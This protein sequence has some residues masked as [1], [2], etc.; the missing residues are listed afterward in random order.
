MPSSLRDTTNRV[1]EALFKKGLLTEPQLKEA[2]EKQRLSG[3][4]LG[5]VLIDLGYVTENQVTEALSE[6]LGIP[7]IDVSTYQIDPKIFALFPEEMLREH[8]ILPLFKVDKTITVA[9]VDPLNIRVTDRLRFLTHCE[10][11]PL[12]GA[13]SAVLRALDKNLGSAG[14]LEKVMRDIKLQDGAKA[15]ALVRPM[16]G[17][18]SLTSV[19]GS[20]KP[21]AA[22]QVT[23]LIAAAENAPVVKI[24]DTIIK[25]AVENRA[26]DIHIEP[27]ESS[28]YLRYR[29]DGV[30]YDVPPP[31]KN[32]EAAV[33]SRIKIMG[34]MDIAERRLP[35]DG[36][37]QVHYGEKEID[38]RVSS[39]PTIYG[40]NLSLRVLDKSAITLN[41]EDL[42]FDKEVLRKYKELLNRPHGILLVTG[43][44]GCGKT[45]TLYASLRTI[46]AVEKN[47]ITLEDPVEYRIQRV[48][49]AQVDVKA[50][51]TF[52]NGLRSILRQDPDII[53][54]G[55]IRDLETAEIAIH[56]ALTGHMVFSTL[57][58]N[59]APGAL[60]RLAD[61]GVEPFLAVSSVVGVLA[62]RLVRSLC[63]ECK[64]P[65]KPTPEILKSLGVDPKK[66]VT[67]Y[68]TKGCEACKQ[69]GYRGRAALFEL[70]ETSDKIRDLLL[71]KASSAELKEQAIRDGMINLRRDGVEK[72]IKGVTTVEEVLRVTEQDFQE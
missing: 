32:L 14:S 21:A 43:P 6:Q 53:L 50:G 20:G 65:Y 16:G 45:T 17:G 36:R 26:S 10:I 51:L 31:P 23:S 57:H 7:F 40:E 52:A 5:E 70:M 1:G 61:M 54:I 49:Q 11:E 48:R 42:G 22:D 56:S 8:L 34:N 69:T 72:V 9:M 59:D 38:L 13:K 37:I 66:E 71:K 35:Q 55:E 33:I 58:T 18:K 60:N 15:P 29:I 2:A 24:V 62:Q 27:E 39:F 68:Q 47:V 19:S 3:R 64:K 30:L 46:N 63:A 67:L 44:T 41:L 28:T 4:M 25:Q 12:F